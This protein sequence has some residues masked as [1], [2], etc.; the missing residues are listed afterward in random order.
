MLTEQTSFSEIDK[1][2]IIT[3]DELEVNELNDYNVHF[4]MNKALKM[5]SLA[6]ITDGWIYSQLF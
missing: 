1:V 4:Y 6:V 5:S 3:K 2:S